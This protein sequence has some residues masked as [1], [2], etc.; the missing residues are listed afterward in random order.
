MCRYISIYVYICI[1]CMYACLLGVHAQPHYWLDLGP[2]SCG[3]LTSNGLLDLAA[4]NMSCESEDLGGSTNPFT[5]NNN[6]DTG[7]SFP[8]T[9]SQKGYDARTGWSSLVVP[10]SRHLNFR[11]KGDFLRISL[12]GY[13]FTALISSDCRLLPCIEAVDSAWRKLLLLGSHNNT[14]CYDILSKWFSLL[15]KVQT[16]L[17]M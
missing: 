11:R 12:D 8:E 5:E 4:S 17:V 7:I 14:Q 6:E 16:C 15:W 2:W 1:V 10:R 13:L 3:S 9:T